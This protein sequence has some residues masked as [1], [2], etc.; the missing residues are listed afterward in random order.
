MSDNQQTLQ[1]VRQIVGAIKKI[2]LSAHP[3]D[4]ALQLDSIERITLLVELE[5]NFQAEFDASSIMPE[6]FESLASLIQL[7]EAQCGEA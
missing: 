5:N 7:V 1:Q 3:I 4:E 2:D 6:S